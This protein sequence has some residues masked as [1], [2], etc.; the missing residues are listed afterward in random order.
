MCLVL[1]AYRQHPDYELILAANRDEFYARP[2]ARASFWADYPDVLAGRDL[3]AGGTWLGITKSGRFAALTNYRDP[4]WEVSGRKS[5]GEVVSN[6]LCSKTAPASYA[7]ILRRTGA[8]YNGFNV[9]FGD[10]NSLWY[11]SNVTGE[12]VQ[13]AP[14]LYGLCNHLIDTPWPKVERS[15]SQLAESL[16]SVPLSKDKL[17]ALL[18]NKNP[19]PD[20]ELP[21]TGVGLTWERILSPIFVESETY[22]T[23]CSTILTIDKA[24]TVEF[25]ERTY[26]PH[27]NLYEDVSYAFAAGAV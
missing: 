14:G 25:L 15:K 9:V 17:L 3:Q 1:L 5:R 4:A 23:R 11:Y 6:Y 7:E 24:G 22:G 16:K 12:P 10:L 8:E 21:D 27:T 2:T 20:H 13:L 18:H 19:V 26:T